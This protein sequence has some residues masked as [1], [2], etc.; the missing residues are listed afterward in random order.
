MADWHVPSAPELIRVAGAALAHNPGANLRLG[1]AL[2][3]ARQWLD[4]GL[5]AGIGGASCS[6]N[7]TLF[8]ALRF[9]SFVSR[10]RSHDPAN[11]NFL[12]ANDP[13]NQLVHSA[14]GSAVDSVM[15]AGRM[16]LDRGA[17]TGTDLA[18]ARARIEA[19]LAELRGLNRDLKTL[20]DARQDVVARFCTS[21]SRHPYP[22]RALAGADY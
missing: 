12:P 7:Q 21:L 5:T 9:A 18:Q 20:V 2:A 15:V 16:V 19:S 1:A 14:A 3:A 13:T 8:A 22:A 4:A 10:V 17:V 11:L 6:N